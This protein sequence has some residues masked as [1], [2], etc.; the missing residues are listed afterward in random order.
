MPCSK[1]HVE[2]LKCV[3]FPLS[4][5]TEAPFNAVRGWCAAVGTTLRGGSPT[6]PPNGA[7]FTNVP[8]AMRY[9]IPKAKKV[10]LGL[11][12]CLDLHKL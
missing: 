11:Q 1:C 7:P 5:R 3:G 2:G 8:K 6:D 9:L 12:Q 10:N 4:T